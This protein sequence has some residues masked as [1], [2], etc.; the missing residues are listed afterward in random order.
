M[1]EQ[2][3]SPEP[4]NPW[5][6]P[7][8]NTDESDLTS[9]VG[10]RWGDIH[11]G[12]DIAASHGYPVVAT[13]AGKVIDVNTSCTHDYGKSKS[14]GC[15]GGYGNRV[16]IDHQDGFITR[17]AHMSRVIVTEGMYVER[18]ETIG[19]VGSTGWST[20]NHLHF[21]IR[22][23]KNY[24]DPELYLNSAFT[25]YNSN[26]ADSIALADEAADTVPYQPISIT[27]AR[28]YDS[29]PQPMHAYVNISIGGK[30]LT[31]KPNVIQN[32]EI[33]RYQ[34]VGDKATFTIFDDSWGSIERA[35]ADNS[36]N[37]QIEYG[38]SDGVSLKFSR[39]LLL[40][41]SLSFNSTGVVM[42][43]QA[44][45][46][47]SL[48]NLDQMTIDGMAEYNPT[49]AIKTICKNIEGLVVED[50]NFVATEDLD[51]E[52]DSP[53]SL[54]N[55]Y[56][57][58]YI[59]DNILPYAHTPD[60]DIVTFDI[61][62]N[63]ATL[64]AEK[65]S[66]EGE[67]LRTYIFQKGYDSPVIDLTFDIK[68]VFGGTSEYKTATGYRSSVFDPL[69][70]E[71]I[72]GEQTLGSVLATGITTGLYAHTRSDQ[73]I[74]SVDSAGH[75]VTRMK[76][77]LYYD[78]KKMATESYEADMTIVGDPTIKLLDKVWIINV[79]DE[80]YLHHTS[81]CYMITGIVDSVDNGSM[82]TQ[83]H[84]VRNGDI[85]EGV[86]ILSPKSVLK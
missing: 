22:K 78:I 42:T 53:F 27:G 11:E 23:G 6:W 62:N 39:M 30:P 71:E 61:S 8:P 9:G 72:Q 50:Q 76:N 29:T 36:D 25:E 17:Y 74:P 48:D 52:K 84:L 31:N 13:R 45:S 49:E 12:I 56:P 33:T 26:I 5:L 21:E 81:G 38:Y 7:V 60:G 37:V 83:L 63:V 79:T 3:F 18:G 46:Q 54:I 68:G 85:S 4:F 44:I 14:C 66:I 65:I 77:R 70:K 82:T 47:D 41:Y 24:L 16:Y 86:E 15:G 55:D 28:V 32:F 40:N 34:G 2:G 75:S 80:G 43:V 58:T 67:G 10:P 35:F 73:S 19:Y 69:T 20:G 59:Y 1:E 51:K 57:L 64:K